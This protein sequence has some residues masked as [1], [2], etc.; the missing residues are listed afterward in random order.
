LEALDLAIQLA[1]YGQPLNDRA[2]E[3]EARSMLA[4]DGSYLAPMQTI[5]DRRGKVGVPE[6]DMVKLVEALMMNRELN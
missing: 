1:L 5:R 3:A 2:G 6:N 4:P